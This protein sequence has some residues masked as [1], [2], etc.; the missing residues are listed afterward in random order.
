MAKI[1]LIGGDITK[2]NVDAIVNNASSSLLGGG[3]VDGAI[4]A[5]AGPGLLEECKLLNGCATGFAKITKGYSLPAKYVIHTVGPIYGRENGQEEELLAS[6]Y[7]STLRLAKDHEVKTIAFP[8]L[9]TGIFGYPIEEAARIAIS[10][11][12]EFINIHDCFDEIRFV[13]YTDYDYKTFKDMYDKMVVS[14]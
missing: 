9:A 10:S 12:Q 14:L 8:A 13:M 2:Q 5:A 3:G 6:C 4:H 1:T 7:A 11:V